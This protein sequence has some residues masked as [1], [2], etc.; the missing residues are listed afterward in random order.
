M[1]RESREKAW[2]ESADSSSAA[3]MRK[4]GQPI[5]V[6]GPFVAPVSLWS[7]VTTTTATRAATVSM[8]AQTLRPAERFCSVGANCTHKQHVVSIYMQLLLNVSNDLQWYHSKHV[9]IKEG[10]RSSTGTV[11]LLLRFTHHLRC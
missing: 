4:L 5:F 3:V 8:S 7:F 2:L 10:Q 1:R 9:S 6:R 11:S